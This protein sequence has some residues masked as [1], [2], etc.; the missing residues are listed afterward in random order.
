MDL[1]LIRPEKVE[2]HRDVVFAVL[3]IDHG[4]LQ[5]PQLPA[6]VPSSMPS[7]ANMTSR[8]QKKIM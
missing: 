5:V 7:I 1:K 6:L 2:S 3:G 8:A 4:S